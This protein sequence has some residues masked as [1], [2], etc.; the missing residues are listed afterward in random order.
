[1][2]RSVYLKTRAFVFGVRLHTNSVRGAAITVCSSEVPDDT[3]VLCKAACQEDCTSQRPAEFSI[4]QLFLPCALLHH[5][6]TSRWHLNAWPLFQVC[7]WLLQHAIGSIVAGDL[8]C[9][10]DSLEM[11]L[12]KAMLP[13]LQDCWLAVHPDDPGHTANALSNSFTKRSVIKICFCGALASTPHVQR[14]QGI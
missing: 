1:M 7:V 5:L 13:Q 11:A 8:N 10:P 3:A 12:L 6:V 4:S 9:P 2:L 14:T